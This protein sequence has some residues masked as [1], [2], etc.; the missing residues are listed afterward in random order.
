VK[1]GLMKGIAYA[2]MIVGFSTLGPLYD[3]MPPGIGRSLVNV[4]TMIV[5]AIG[6]EMHSNEVKKEILEEVKRINLK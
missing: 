1:V 5:V 4:L 6:F 3:R 2:V